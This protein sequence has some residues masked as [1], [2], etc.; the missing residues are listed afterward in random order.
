MTVLWGVVVICAPMFWVAFVE[1][2]LVW[3]VPGVL[4]ALLAR[5]APS[6]QA[7]AG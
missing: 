7:E 2:R 5:L 6:R 3:M 1:R 4:I